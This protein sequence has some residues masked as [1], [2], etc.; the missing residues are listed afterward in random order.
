MAT[1]FSPTAEDVRRYRRVRS[2]SIEINNQIVRT[3]PRQ[4]TEEIGK[5][6]GIADGDKL[7]FDT[8]D[9]LAVFADC[10]LYDWYEDGK[11]L[12]TRYIEAH[13]AEPGSDQALLFDAYL[14]AEYR[15]LVPESAVP[16][17]GIYCEDVP[18]GGELFLMD[19]GYSQSLANSGMAVATRAF[20]M[21]GYWMTGGAGLPI[22]SVEVAKALGEAARRN[23]PEQSGVVPLG[24]T[25]A[26]LEAGAGERIKYRP[27]ELQPEKALKMP[28]WKPKRRR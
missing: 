14:R 13:P 12:M 28:R 25:R 22:P 20:P 10:C 18:N 3:I 11:N 15:I 9:M 24:I 8:P 19:V 17:A 2:I 23:A 1:T 4:A 7:Y 21:G 6:L 26:C 5:A 27:P 16:G